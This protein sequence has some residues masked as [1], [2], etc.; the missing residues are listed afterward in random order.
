MGLLEAQKRGSLTFS[1]EFLK[2]QACMY[3]STRFSL[4]FLDLTTGLP[5]SSLTIYRVIWPCGDMLLAEM[6]L[7]LQHCRL[8]KCYYKKSPDNAIY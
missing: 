4:V 7:S 5:L 8:S 6:L 1:F 2:K 3:S